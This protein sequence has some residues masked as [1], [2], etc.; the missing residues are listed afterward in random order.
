MLL[1]VLWGAAPARAAPQDA[2]E[3]TLWIEGMS[4]AILRV[5]GENVPAVAYMDLSRCSWNWNPNTQEIASIEAAAKT[6]VNGGDCKT[7][8][9]NAGK[10]NQYKA[11]VRT[12]CRAQARAARSL[13]FAE[14]LIESFALDHCSAKTTQP[15]ADGLIQLQAVFAKDGAT[16]CLQ[17]GWHPPSS[18]TTLRISASCD[19]STTR[20]TDDVSLATVYGSEE[21]AWQLR[22]ESGVWTS[23]AA[24]DFSGAPSYVTRWA[25]AVSRA[26]PKAL[27]LPSTDPLGARP[28]EGAITAHLLGRWALAF[29]SDPN[30]NL[31]L[32]L[33]DWMARMQLLN[34]QDAARTLFRRECAATAPP[35]ASCNN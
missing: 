17:V 8:F 26:S 7:R 31:D 2:L 35:M 24:S 20:P 22:Y 21:V 33:R 13:V 28:T 16:F 32:H 15:G 9:F 4:Q 3:P 29:A 12:D 27:I 18:S 23:T 25:D 11:V 30:S 34:T 10:D 6:A 1:L 5:Y 14:Q 19:S